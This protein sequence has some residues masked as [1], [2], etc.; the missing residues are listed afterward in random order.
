MV[1]YVHYD[2][3]GQELRNVRMEPQADDLFVVPPGYTEDESPFSVAFD[4]IARH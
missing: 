4:S 3:D 2:G 1:R